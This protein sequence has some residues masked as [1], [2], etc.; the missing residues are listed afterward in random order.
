MGFTQLLVQILPLYLLALFGWLAGRR[1]QLSSESLAKLL[2]YVVIPG[3]VFRGALITPVTPATMVL[4]LATFGLCMALCLLFYLAC[5]ALWTDSRRNMAAAAAGLGNFG[6]FGLP[7]ALGVLGPEAEG[8]YIMALLGPMFYNFSAGFIMAAKG[9]LSSRESLARVLRLPTPYAFAL[10]L[11]LNALQV[12][13][14]DSILQLTEAFRGA[15]TVLGMMLVG[16]SLSSMKSFVPDWTFMTVTLGS[17]FVAWPLAALAAIW[18][19]AH[20]LM[21]FTPLVYKILVIYAIVPL[22][23]SSVVLASLFQTNED[24]MASAVLVSTLFAAPYVPL[25]LSFL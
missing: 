5:G 1:L 21:L 2:F 20:T 18:L 6:F 12:P 3:T 16:V 22:A 24:Q 15:Y 9:R 11:A 10:G 23:A 14:P 4:P 19:D 7:L 8:P 13:V 25:V 17:K